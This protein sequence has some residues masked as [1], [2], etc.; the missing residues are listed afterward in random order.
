MIGI[1]K[2]Y[3]LRHQYNSNGTGLRLQVVELHANGRRTDARKIAT[4]RTVS[5]VLG[6]MEDVYAIKDREYRMYLLLY[7]VGRR[8]SPIVVVN[9][10]T[11]TGDG[12]GLLDL[13]RLLQRDHHG[14]HVSNG[15]GLATMCVNVVNLGA[16]SVKNVLLVASGRVN[17]NGSQLR[18]ALDRSVLEHA[19]FPVPGLLAVIGIGQSESALLYH[20]LNGNGHQLGTVLKRQQHGAHRIRVHGALGRYVGIVYLKEGGEGE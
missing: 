14:A 18:T 16:R 11:L 13:Q 6:L 1:A 10:R 9:Q 7:T 5:S 3:V 20:Y 17:G 15:V 4:T 2:S 19:L 12:H 8:T